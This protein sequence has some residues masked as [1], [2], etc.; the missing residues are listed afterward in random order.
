MSQSLAQ[1]RA[2]H[3][4]ARVQARE[5]AGKSTYGNYVAYVSALPATILTNG[6]GQAAATLLS[7]AKGKMKDAHHLLY[8]DLASW[9][10]GDDSV[11]PY[12]K[13]KS[14]GRLMT[15]ITTNTEADYLRAQAEALAYLV[16]LKKFANAFLEPGKPD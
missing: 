6:L 3:A 16:W 4:L 2:A 15:A 11:A 13:H 7:R 5:H 10:C 14:N 1:R 12:P 9:L 8:D